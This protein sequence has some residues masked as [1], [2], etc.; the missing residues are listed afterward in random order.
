[1]I[2]ERLEG[3]FSVCRVSELRAEDV[4]RPFTF[5]AA[6]DCEFSLVCDTSC[7]P[8]DA[9]KRD[10]GWTAY[11]VQGSLDFS[12]VGILASLADAL[13]AKKSPLFAVSTYE[14]DYILTQQ[15][16]AAEAAWREAGH[17]V[18]GRNEA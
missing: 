4:N 1:M 10:D 7:A 14:T 9:L 16:E 6:T 17:E 18:K 15:P 5:T 12:L 11:R 8:Q 13:A 2:L 3:S